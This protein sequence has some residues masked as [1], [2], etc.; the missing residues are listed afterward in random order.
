MSE[1]EDTLVFQIKAVNLPT[2]A[3]EHKF[4]KTRRWR[5][6][7][8]WPDKMLAVEAEG[9]VWSGGRHGTGVGF[10]ADCEKYS[11]AVLLGWRVMRFTG[12]QIKGGYAINCIERAL[13]K[14]A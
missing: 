3:R 6:D 7:L 12:D 4:H 9:G 2:P 8:A 11:E 5:F 14:R 1:L 13:S 10:T